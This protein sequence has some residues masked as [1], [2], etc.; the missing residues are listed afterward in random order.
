MAT[1]VAG[2]ASWRCIGIAGAVRHL[3][4]ERLSYIMGQSMPVDAGFIM[5]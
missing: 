5:R 1:D 3:C 2:G 4:S